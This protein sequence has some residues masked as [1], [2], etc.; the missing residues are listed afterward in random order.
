[1]T[2]YATYTVSSNVG[3]DSMQFMR[4]HLV[5]SYVIVIITTLKYL[6]SFCVFLS[7]FAEASCIKRLSLM[8]MDINKSIFIILV[9]SIPDT[10]ISRIQYIIAFLFTIDVF[11]LR[12]K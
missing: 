1:M 11:A 10:S 5:V 4:E 6:F 3:D 2:D 7:S 9:K 12:P 8:N